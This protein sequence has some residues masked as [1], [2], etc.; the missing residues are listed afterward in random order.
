[1][2]HTGG[3]PLN[4]QK[5]QEMKIKTSVEMSLPATDL[6]MVLGERFASVSE[7]ADSIV[8]SSLD[9]SLGEGAVRTCDLK[10]TGPLPAGQV[11]EELTRFDASAR[12]MTYVVKSGV[13]GFM[14]YLDNAWTI[15]DLGDG[16]SRVTSVLTL[17]MAWWSLPLYPMIRLQLGKTL[18]G[19]IEQLETH[20]ANNPTLAAEPVPAT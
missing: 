3:C 13:P 17:N 2:Y 12:A 15:E 9:G 8:K 20:V 18:R 5:R 10:Q 6:W 1:M 4:G 16:R 19:F 14:R 11:T 7:W